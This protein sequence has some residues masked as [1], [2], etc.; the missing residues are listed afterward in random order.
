MVGCIARTGHRLMAYGCYK[1]YFVFTVTPAPPKPLSPW[2]S[3]VLPKHLD[4]LR[5]HPAIS[6]WHVCTDNN[7]VYNDKDCRCPWLPS[8]GAETQEIV[9]RLGTKFR[10]VCRKT[11]LMKTATFWLILLLFTRFVMQVYT[12]WKEFILLL[13]HSC[14]SRKA[15]T[16]LIML[17]ISKSRPSTSFSKRYA[18][19]CLFTLMRYCVND[20]HVMAASPSTHTPATYTNN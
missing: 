1:Q 20:S 4:W 3:Q 18:F 13:Q 12:R 6:I 9:I 7:I 17:F 16:R 8:F 5:V 10:N 15:V 2:R 11:K 14:I 19:N